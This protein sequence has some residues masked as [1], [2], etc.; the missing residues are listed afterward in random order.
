MAIEYECV[1]PRLSRTF[2]SPTN[3]SS[4]SPGRAPAP[5]RSAQAHCS[6]THAARREPCETEPWP[7]PLQPPRAGSGWKPAPANCRAASASSCI[8]ARYRAQQQQPSSGQRREVNTQE[9]VPEEGPPPPAPQQTTRSRDP[10]RRK[11]QRDPSGNHSEGRKD[12]E[13]KEAPGKTKTS[14]AGGMQ[15][16][17]LWS[18]SGE[19][20]PTES[21]GGSGKGPREERAQAGPSAKEGASGSPA[22]AAREK[23]RNRGTR[24]TNGVGQT[25]S[26]RLQQ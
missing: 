15:K 11:Q 20:D 13:S 21:L 26:C 9:Q 22:A 7:P 4:C 14:R 12:P 16:P 19:E 10:R 24:E 23:P 6:P 3:L 5:E 2:P 1:N 18:V 8:A 25:Q 17:G